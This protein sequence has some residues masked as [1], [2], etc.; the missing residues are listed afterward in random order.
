[1]V[2]YD[3]GIMSNHV[4]LIITTKTEEQ[5]ISATIRDF[6]KYNLRRFQRRLGKYQRAEKGTLIDGSTMLLPN[7]SV[8]FLCDLRQENDSI[9][10]LEKV[11]HNSVVS[12]PE[13]FVLFLWSSNELLVIFWIAQIVVST[14]FFAVKALPLTEYAVVS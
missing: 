9:H 8:E 4:H 10:Y 2:V 3:W 13:L 14:P 5:N 6:K 1:L 12:V 7:T 11:S